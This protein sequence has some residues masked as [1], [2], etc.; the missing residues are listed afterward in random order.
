VQGLKEAGIAHTLVGDGT[1][2]IL[3]LAHDPAMLA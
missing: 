3:R 2:E 1:D